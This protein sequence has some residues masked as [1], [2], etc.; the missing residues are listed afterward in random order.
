MKKSLKTI[1][2]LA[3]ALVM[4]VGLAACSGSSSSTP[5]ASTP[6]DG[7]GDGGNVS[8]GPIHVSMYYA[9]NPTLPWKDDWLA[10]V[11]TAEICGL[12]LEVE[13]I[14]SAELGTKVSLALNT[15]ENCPDVI[16]YQT[17]KGENA[18]LPS[19]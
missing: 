12:E 9:D 13:A 5:A 18:S 17:T 2:A 6:A 16:L 7:G 3:M 14:P 4:L 11:K 19:L 8:S 10:A 1:L 15:Q